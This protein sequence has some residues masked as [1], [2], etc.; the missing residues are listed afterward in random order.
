M[1]YSETFKRYK[2]I[3]EFYAYTVVFLKKKERKKVNREIKSKY[4]CRGRK[5]WIY[6]PGTVK[7][8]I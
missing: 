1:C 6:Q 5:S 2:I 4:R 3:N 7:D 8:T